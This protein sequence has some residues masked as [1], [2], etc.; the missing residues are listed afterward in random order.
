MLERLHERS[1]VIAGTGR[2]QSLQLTAEEFERSRRSAFARFAMARGESLPASVYPLIIRPVVRCFSRPEGHIIPSC[3]LNLAITDTTWKI[4]HGVK[5]TRSARRRTWAT[6]FRDARLSIDG[7][8]APDQDIDRIPKRVAFLC[9]AGGNRSSASWSSSPSS[10]GSAHRCANFWAT[11]K[12][13]A[14]APRSSTLVQRVTSARSHSRAAL[15]HHARSASLSPAASRPTTTYQCCGASCP[16]AVFGLE[17]P[18]ES[19]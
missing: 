9:S 18:G 14:C 3:I 4:V 15:R 16:M 2:E 7:F 6:L 19:V 11:S 17:I 13:S 1:K 10:W 12:R 5:R 8:S